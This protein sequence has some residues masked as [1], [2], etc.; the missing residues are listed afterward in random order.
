V[1]FEATRQRAQAILARVTSN[2][3]SRRPPSDLLIDDSGEAAQLTLSQCRPLLFLRQTRA[4]G[5]AVA[6]SENC[7]H[8]QTKGSHGTG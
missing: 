3:E 5:Q 2:V 6:E 1:V 4:A 7:F 8:H